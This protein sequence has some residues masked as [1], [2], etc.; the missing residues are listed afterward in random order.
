MAFYTKTITIDN[1][2]W[3]QKTWRKF[4]NFFEVVAY[5]RAARALAAIGRH[6]EAKYCIMQIKNLREQ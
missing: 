6:E 2:T 4:T 3:F 1:R 5:A